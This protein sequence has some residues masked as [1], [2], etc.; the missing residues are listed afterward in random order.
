MF[1]C[2]AMWLYCRNSLGVKGGSFGSV[3]SVDV[4]ADVVVVVVVVVS[5]D[6]VAGAGHS[7]AAAIFCGSYAAEA[8][9]AIS[10]AEECRTR[11]CGVVWAE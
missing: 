6:V 9:E 8:E 4:D 5:A 10:A 3:G 11:N 7:D 2:S 1:M